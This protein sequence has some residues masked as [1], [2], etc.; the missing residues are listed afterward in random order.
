LKIYYN[1]K[2][3]KKITKM[4]VWVNVMNSGLSALVL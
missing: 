4:E 1:E 2:L 3:A